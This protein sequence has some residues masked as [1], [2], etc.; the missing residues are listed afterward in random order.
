[1]EL[2]CPVTLM[3]TLSSTQKVSYKYCLYIVVGLETNYA[4]TFVCV[5]AGITVADMLNGRTYG[6]MQSIHQ[7]LAENLQG[8]YS[9]R[10]TN[11]HTLQFT[12]KS[13]RKE[14]SFDLLISPWW[15]SKEQ[16]LN[17]LSGKPWSTVRMYE[18]CDH[19]YT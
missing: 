9:W 13:G 10:A 19:V 1:M 5:F 3:L 2:Q 6:W 7:H 12:V 8:Q 17:Y 4:C 14:V 11:V 16:L 18:T 15:D